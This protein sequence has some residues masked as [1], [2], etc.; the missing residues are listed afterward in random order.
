VTLQTIA[1]NAGLGFLPL[2]EERYDFIVPK[3]RAN[4]HG[5]LAFRA[6]LADVAIQD[7]L[8][9]LGMTLGSASS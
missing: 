7:A 8:A 4:R 9:R 5:V 6:L 2:Q 1:F 3:S